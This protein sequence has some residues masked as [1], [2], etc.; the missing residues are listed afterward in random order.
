MEG[1]RNILQKISRLIS[2]RGDLE[3]HISEIINK[4]TGASLRPRKDFTI[5][6]DELRLH[7]PAI[8]RSEI[9]LHKDAILEELHALCEEKHFDTQIITI[10]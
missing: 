6:K 7:V 4:H 3:T 8:L 2:E 10:R 9:L 5:E 1:D